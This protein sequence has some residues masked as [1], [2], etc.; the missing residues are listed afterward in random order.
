M[1]KNKLELKENEFKSLKK[2][3]KVYTNYYKA[4]YNLNPSLAEDFLKKNEYYLNERI[5]Q[6]KA[7]NK[8]QKDDCCYYENKTRT[9]SK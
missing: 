2:V 8:E 4:L 5:K 7:N 9:K 1:D 3:L 6:K